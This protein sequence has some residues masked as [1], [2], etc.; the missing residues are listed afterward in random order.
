MFA[1]KNL[2]LIA[3]FLRDIFLI[4]KFFNIEIIEKHNVIFYYIVIVHKNDKI[5]KAR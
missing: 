5:M 1:Y 4:L 3:I 2:L